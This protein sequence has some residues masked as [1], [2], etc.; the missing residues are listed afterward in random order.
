MKLVKSFLLI[1]AI[2]C[3]VQSQPASSSWLTPAEHQKFDHMRISG[4]EAL[5]NLDYEGARKIFK[6]MAAAFPN[7]PAG[8][9]FLADTL[10][11]EAL[12]QTRRLQASLYNSD[13]FYSENE[14]KADPKLVDQFRTYT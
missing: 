13:S 7:Y 14:D 10:L 5:Y 2:A 11:I 9:Q 1:C 6:E 8:P 3:A 12:Y 4:S